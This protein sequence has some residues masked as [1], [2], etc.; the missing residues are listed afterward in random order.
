MRRKKV[1]ADSSTL[2][3]VSVAVAE[4]SLPRCHPSLFSCFAINA[5]AVLN[6]QPY[7][8]EIT[9][10]K[11]VSCFMFRPTSITAV[12]TKRRCGSCFRFLNHNISPPPSAGLSRTVSWFTLCIKQP[13]TL[14]LGSICFLLSQ[15][16]NPL[17]YFHS[18]ICSPNSGFSC[19]AR[20]M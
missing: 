14:K 8:L 5:I 17:S 10:L 2:T 3:R 12:I 1:V 15:C 19:F 20:P 9:V 4:M 7:V 13:T 18:P 6:Q 16:I 11:N